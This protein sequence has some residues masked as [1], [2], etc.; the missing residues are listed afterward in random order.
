MCRKQVMQNKNIINTGRLLIPSRQR[1][2]NLWT[3]KRSCRALIPTRLSSAAI[4]STAH[5]FRLVGKRNSPRPGLPCFDHGTKRAHSVHHLVLDEI[6]ISAS[7]MELSS[8]HN[9]MCALAI[10]WERDDDECSRASGR[11]YCSF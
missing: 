8:I 7:H 2:G 9:K 4:V 10:A 3:V 1:K 6:G 5:T 11:A